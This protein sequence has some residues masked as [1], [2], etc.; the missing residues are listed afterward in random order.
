MMR[1]CVQREGAAHLRDRLALRLLRNQY[2][3]AT[4]DQLMAIT[5][6]VRHS[7]FPGYNG[8]SPGLHNEQF[9][10][11]A[12]DSESVFLSS[13]FPDLNLPSY[14]PATAAIRRQYF[15]SVEESFGTQRCAALRLVS[16]QLNSQVP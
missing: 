16:H 4:A 9:T 10:R 3:A 1:F 15:N 7:I 12:S 14:V 6:T 13:C 8:N 2:T 5:A 11:M